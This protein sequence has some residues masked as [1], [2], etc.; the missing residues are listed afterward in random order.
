MRLLPWGQAFGRWS[1]MGAT[2]CDKDKKVMVLHV[3]CMSK[4]QNIFVPQDSEDQNNLPYVQ[5]QV[6][7]CGW[8][9]E[10]HYHSCEP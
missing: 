7:G 8:K 6:W 10:T 9:T 4:N 5:G 1:F 3:T 2:L